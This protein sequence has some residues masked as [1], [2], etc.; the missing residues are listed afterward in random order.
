ME[1]GTFILEKPT[2]WTEIGDKD[3]NKIINTVKDRFSTHRES[4][5]VE[6]CKII[7]K[8]PSSKKGYSY[9]KIKAK[10]YLRSKNV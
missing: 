7:Q 4:A 3:S 2:N 8:D 5:Y 9:F 10:Y 1:K 6:S